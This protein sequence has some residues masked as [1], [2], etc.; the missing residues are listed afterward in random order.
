MIFK[1]MQPSQDKE[2]GADMLVS[3]SG[4]QSGLDI[5][6]LEGVQDKHAHDVCLDTTYQEVTS[7]CNVCIVELV[8]PKELELLQSTSQGF[9]HCPK[10]FK[11][12][13]LV[14]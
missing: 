3:S 8:T 12:C 2:V 5:M 11:L 1:V 13:W 6:T 14:C 10:G 9:Q 4:S 7:K